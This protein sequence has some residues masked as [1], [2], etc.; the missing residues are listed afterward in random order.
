[1]KRIYH[2]WNTILLK[3]LMKKETELD[4]GCEETQIKWI[5]AQFSS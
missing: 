5:A 3:Y 4:H 2:C 1:M